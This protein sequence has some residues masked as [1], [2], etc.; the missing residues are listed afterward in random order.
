MG[1]SFF[2]GTRK[3]DR[4]SLAGAVFL[5]VILIIAT[6]G[7]V[8][9]PVVFVEQIRKEGLEVFFSA[10]TVA[11]IALALEMG[12]GLALVLGVRHLIVLLPTS[13]MVAFFLFLTARTYWM[14]LTGQREDS[15]D[16][17]CFGVF[18]Q[19]NASQA[20]W[21]DLFLLLPAL[22]LIYCSREAIYRWPK[23]WKLVVSAVAALVIVIYTAGFAGMP[24]SDIG[25][26][27]EEA[28]DGNRLQP[29]QQFVLYVDGEADPEGE[30][31]ESD[32]SLQLLL[33]TP[34]LKTPLLLD[35]LSNGVKALERSLIQKQADGSVL[36]E[37]PAELETLTQFSI[38]AAGLS[39]EVEGHL[40]ELRSP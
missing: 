39:F 26:Y 7:K 38:G 33:M 13:A 29:S 27:V 32:S 30:V 23:T 25:G 8:L 22:L 10:N 36:L 2:E 12:L 19:R 40:L 24:P 35:V 14:V 5:G 28:T 20:F 1:R 31:Y 6:V 9:D 11:L 18:L 17:G 15:F 37:T 16:C 34:T 4:I 21:Q 3:W